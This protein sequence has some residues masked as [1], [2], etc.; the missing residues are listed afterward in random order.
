[1]ILVHS[2]C[3]SMGDH[4][5]S[6]VSK[7]K[8]FALQDFSFRKLT[9]PSERLCQ[10]TLP[11]PGV[12]ALTHPLTPLTGDHGGS[13][14]IFFKKKR[15]YSLCAVRSTLSK[16]EGFPGGSG[17]SFSFGANVT[18]VS[19]PAHSLLRKTVTLRADSCL[20]PFHPS[21]Q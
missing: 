16:Q 15:N 3:V 19:L 4:P 20:V 17:F 14:I 7:S 6:R 9:R 18:I 13:F 12:S 2:S 21:W 5:R 11:Q 10:A 1:M 8:G